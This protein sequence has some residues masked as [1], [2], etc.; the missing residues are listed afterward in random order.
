VL[1]K[2][3]ESTGPVARDEIASLWPDALQ[4]DRAII[5]LLDDGLI[6]SSGDALSLP[7][8]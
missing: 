7:T 2:L 8:D 5:S 4:L 3:R 6:V 1:K